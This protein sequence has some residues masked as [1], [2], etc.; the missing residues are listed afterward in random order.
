MEESNSPGQSTV[1]MVN[2]YEDAMDELYSVFYHQTGILICQDLPDIYVFATETEINL[3]ERGTV[4]LLVSIKGVFLY[5]I[6]EINGVIFRHGYRNRSFSYAYVKNGTVNIVDILSI[7]RDDPGIEKE[8][9]M[10][11]LYLIYSDLVIRVEFEKFRVTF[12]NNFEQSLHL[13]QGP[14]ALQEKK[15]YMD[16]SKAYYEKNKNKKIPLGDYDRR[17]SIEIGKN[18]ILYCHES[19]SYPKIIKNCLGHFTSDGEYLIFYQN[20]Y[21]NNSILFG[22]INTQSGKKKNILLKY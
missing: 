19:F 17:I 15:Y 18:Y 10:S 5:E 9:G 16:I 11:I 21:R 12:D 7:L 3:Y 6:S 8:L 2:L 13:L 20:N 14:T 4:N 1:G 22:R